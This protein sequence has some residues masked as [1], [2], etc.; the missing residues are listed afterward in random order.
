[1]PGNKGTL[2]IIG[3]GIAGLC[4]GVY[5]C[6]CGYRV[7]LFEMHDTAGGPARSWERNGYTFETCLPWLPGSNP[8]RPFYAHWHEVFDIGRLRFVHQEEFVRLETEQGEHLSI[9]TNVD[10]LEAELLQRAPEDAPEIRRLA[11]AVRRFSEF[12]LPGLATSR[13]GELLSVL[14]VLP[15]LP[16]LHRWSGIS[17]AEYGRRFSNRLLRA[18]FAAD[19]LGQLSALELVLSLAWM[20]RHEAGYPIGG[21]QAIIGP[22]V[23]NFRRLGG[24]LRL[25]TKVEKILVERDAAVGVRLAGGEVVGAD[26]VIS[27][28]DGHTTIFD[29]LDGR[30]RDKA[31][32]DIYGTLKVFPSYVQVSLGVSRD[33]SHEGGYVT[34]LL[35]APIEIDPATRHCQVSFRFFHFDPTFAPAGKTAVT[36]F[37]P[38]RNVAF[39]TDL[40]QRHPAQ[41][42]REKYRVPEAATAVL[43]RRI[44]E[45]RQATSST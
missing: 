25:G 26:W 5:A 10:R 43:E 33:L 36:C 42:R 8:D 31:I 45:I 12:E 23:D 19:E 1:M 2:A 44:G 6:K 40:Q 21:S 37:L 35:D 41:Y 13:A 20:N 15:S 11:H 27:A 14:R 22:I 18:F 38:T 34:R 29:L 3:G 32:D 7:E 17:I 30:F 9:Y 39:W 4:A 16:R 28:A 24:R